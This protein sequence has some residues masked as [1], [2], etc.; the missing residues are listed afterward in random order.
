MTASSSKYFAERELK[1]HCGCGLALMDE[2]FMER[3]DALRY[4]YNK[5]I[6]L[7]SAYRC[8][9]YNN[10]VSTTGL[11]GPHTTGKAVDIKIFGKHAHIMLDHIM[12]FQFQG[13]GI[14]QKGEHAKRFIHIDDVVEGLRPW[15][16]T[17]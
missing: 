15:V 8:P 1:C 12:Q 9:E 16:W 13:I 14:Q 5:P 2:V 3:M 11:D 17:Y 6:I 7:S 10:K 4:R